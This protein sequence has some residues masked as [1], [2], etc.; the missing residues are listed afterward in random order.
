MLS[1]LLFVLFLIGGTSAASCIDCIC[2]HES[3]CAPIG[4]EMDLGSLSCGYFQI[5]LPY[6]QDCG[7]PGQRNGESDE[8]AWKR[9]HNG[10][11]YGCSDTRTDVYW[12]WVKNCCGCS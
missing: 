1:L 12:A 8:D 3:G 2:Q 7:K 5:K 6:Y 9:I 4:C 10:G 11:P